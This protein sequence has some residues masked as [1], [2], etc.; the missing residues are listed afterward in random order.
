[1]INVSKEQR[2]RYPWILTSAPADLMSQRGFLSEKVTAAIDPT[3][4]DCPLIGGSITAVASSMKVTVLHVR[5]TCHQGTAF[6]TKD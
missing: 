1:M 6:F 5:G 4:E 3:P 2:E